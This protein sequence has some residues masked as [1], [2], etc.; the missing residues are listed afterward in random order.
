MKPLLERLAE[1]DAIIANGT[2]TTEQKKIRAELAGMANAAE[3]M[4]DAL[5]EWQRSKVTGHTLRA[6]EA[7]EIAN[8]LAKI[9]IFYATSFFQDED[10]RALR[11]RP[12]TEYVPYEDTAMDLLHALRTIGKEIEDDYSPLL[13]KHRWKV[14]CEPAIAKA[15]GAAS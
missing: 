8:D 15:T 5:E 13:L 4:L 6:I 14:L 12:H 3:T 2:A 10:D 9:A 7:G 1:L 11:Q